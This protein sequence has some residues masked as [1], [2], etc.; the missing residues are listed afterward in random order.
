MDMGI[1]LVGR[2]SALP[3]ADP[4][5]PAERAAQNREVIQAVRA[6]NKSEMFGDDNMLDFQMDLSTHQMVIRVINRQTKEV[7]DEYPPAYILR[8]AAALKP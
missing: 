1:D 3:A 4:V 5:I 8:M 7:I 6:V 2:N